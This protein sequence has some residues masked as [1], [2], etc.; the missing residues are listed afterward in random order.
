MR[1]MIFEMESLDY[2]KFID[3][4]ASPSTLPYRV[5]QATPG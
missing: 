5:P 4:E 3:N 1:D 2:R